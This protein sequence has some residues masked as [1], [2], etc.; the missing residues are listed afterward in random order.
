MKISIKGM[1]LS[2]VKIIIY[3]L[4]GI[5]FI[6]GAYFLLYETLIYYLF[7]IL[8]SWAFLFRFLIL[9]ALVFILIYLFQL[10]DKRLYG[11]QLSIGFNEKYLE[12]RTARNTYQIP[13]SQLKWLTL[14][15]KNDI[16]S[17]LNIQADQSLNFV[18]GSWVGKLNAPEF[19]NFRNALKKELKQQG[20]EHKV[21]NGK[22]GKTII[23]QELFCKDYSDY[24]NKQNKRKKRTFIYLGIFFVFF[25][26]FTIF[27]VRAFSRDGISISDGEKIESSYFEKYQN[28]VY[29]LKIGDGYFPLPEANPST[30]K[31]LQMEGE[32]F[33]E[34]GADQQ[35]T[36]WQDHKLVLLNPANSVYL[37]GDYTK[38]AQHVYFR[39]QLLAHVDVATFQAIKH[40]QYNTPVYYFG[41]DKNKV[42]YKTI[43]LPGLETETA[44]SFDNSSRYVKDR[45]KVFYKNSFLKG[46]NAELTKVY[47]PE[48]YR[49]AFA[50]DGQHH[51][52]NGEPVPETASNKYF[53]TTDIDLTTFKLLLPAGAG[54]YLYL[55]GDSR[56]LYFYDEKYAKM[57]MVYTFDQPVALR[58]LDNG[59]FT[60]GKFTYTLN[61]RKISTRSRTMTT[62]YGYDAKI[63][64]MESPQNPIEIGSYAARLVEWKKK[65]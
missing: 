31:A 53:G 12:F 28:K 48:H 15:K 52:I 22:Q 38:D 57:V 32:V 25:T 50:T 49:A 40:S 41:K 23:V 35:H 44:R 60:D 54:S 16:Y 47:D 3:M 10:I 46:L 64:R 58:A 17:T 33:S 56:H 63:L 59:N 43:P 5:A 27:L 8:L 45:Q 14:T 21:D 11:T 29:F 36:Y 26:I 24:L 62:T 20:F 42:Y 13:Y 1:Q 55:F 6:A 65:D 30:F 39:D 2:T 61:I 19:E 9:F 37:G 51:F 7:Q 4:L 34:V 18:L